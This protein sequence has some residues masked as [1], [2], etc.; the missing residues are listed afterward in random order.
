[1]ELINSDEFLEFTFLGKVVNEPWKT[2][3]KILGFLFVGIGIVGVFLPVLP[4][5]PFIVIAAYCFS[6]S[7]KKFHD[8][9]RNTKHF[10]PMVCEWEDH[11][12]IRLA[13]KLG[14]TFFILASLAYAFYFDS[15]W[16]IPASI[17]GFGG[18]GL[19]FVWSRP[20]TPKK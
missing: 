11:G 15:H 16:A 5:A 8:W 2:V 12:V 4:T 17:A 1:L 20:S 19:A 13:G 9:I 10:G 6:R 7:S 14:A 18:L 3:L